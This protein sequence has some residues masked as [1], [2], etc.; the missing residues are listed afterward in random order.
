MLI[1]GASVNCIPWVYVPEILPLHA[2]AKGTAVGVSSNWICNFFVVTITPIII[3][4]LQWK[5]Y[6]IFMCT[7]L[8]VVPLVYFCY[9]ETANLTLEEIDYLFTN[10]DK[11][12]VK[13]SKEIRKERR[14]HGQ[15]RRLAGDARLR[16]A[17]SPA[18][19]QEKG[20]GVQ[21]LGEYVED[22]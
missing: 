11:S 8:A 19:S 9:P 18:D 10:P 20:S 22:A 6:L 21:P 15:G 16:R 5:A 17:S 1:F 13:I 7:N 4:R 2:R 12:A 14:T 3:N